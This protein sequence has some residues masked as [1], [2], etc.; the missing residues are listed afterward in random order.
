MLRIAAVSQPQKDPVISGYFSSI[1]P[2]L[3]GHLE[4]LWVDQPIRIITSNCHLRQYIHSLHVPFLSPIKAQRPSTQVYNIV[5][6]YEHDIPIRLVRPGCIS[7]QSCLVTF[8]PPIL[9]SSPQYKTSLVLSWS[10]WYRLINCLVPCFRTWSAL[11]FVSG[12]SRGEPSDSKPIFI[13]N[14]QNSRNV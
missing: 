6:Y 14:S 13:E 5:S 8:W 12:Q 1:R 2:E 7:S 11:A 4:V 9:T 3:S 10:L